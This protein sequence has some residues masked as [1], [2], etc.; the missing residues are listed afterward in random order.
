MNKIL[1]IT[2]CRSSG[3]GE[4][5]GLEKCMSS[6]LFNS[7]N[8]VSE[9]LNSV[10]ISSEVVQVVDNNCIDRE[11]SR[12]KPTH[13][14]IEAL[15]VVPE[16]FEI[17]QKLHPT[18]TWV[19]RLHSEIP[20]IANEGVAMD[21]IIKYAKYPNVKVA[22]N[23]VRMFDDV[24]EII[25]AHYGVGF[26]K[27]F[28][29]FLPNYYQNTTTFDSL[30]KTS[31]KGVINVGCFGAIRPLKNQLTQAV[32]AIKYAK[33]FNKK[34]KFHINTGR[35]EN[36]GNNVLKNI[37]ELFEN[38]D[39][40]DFELVEHVWLP[41]EE[42]LSLCSMMDVGLQVSYSETFNI[43]SADMTTVGIP[44]V[45]SPEIKWSSFLFQ[46]D[47]NEVNDIVSKMR[48]AILLG[49]IGVFL[50]NSGLNKYNY[51]ARNVWFYYFIG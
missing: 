16:K 27:D 34:L 30:E 26:H 47:P 45:T 10:G 15:W 46:A 39:K 19:I 20:F 33:K 50:N 7:A 35:I 12:V 49:R 18:V 38:L 28:M 31:T 21:W 23:S 3:Y 1:F 48:A 51:K 9:M 24:K 25:D 32:A 8:L 22:P 40:A 42:F 4:K 43:V 17:L 6:G 11:V 44:I 14:M 2:K 5:S 29:M 37:R 13:V 41:R 36:N